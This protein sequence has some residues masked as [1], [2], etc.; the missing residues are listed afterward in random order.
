MVPLGMWPEAIVAGYEMQTLKYIWY[1]NDVI[2]F[3][4]S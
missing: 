2:G 1:L 4:F 3:H